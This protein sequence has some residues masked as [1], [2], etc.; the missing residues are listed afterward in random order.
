L[1]ETL[2]LAWAHAGP[3]T[4]KIAQFEKAVRQVRGKS[5]RRAG[6]AAIRSAHSSI[7]NRPLPRSNAR[8]LARAKR[9]DAQGHR[10]GRMRA[11]AAKRMYNL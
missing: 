2:L 10:A 8:M 4:G 1:S 7:A 11:W 5:E 6:G 9:L 3:C